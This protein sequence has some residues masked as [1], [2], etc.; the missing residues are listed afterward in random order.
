MD[1]ERATP[2]DLGPLELRKLRDL[3]L[4]EPSVPLLSATMPVD[5]RFEYRKG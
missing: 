4:E 1:R 2:E 3:D 5:G